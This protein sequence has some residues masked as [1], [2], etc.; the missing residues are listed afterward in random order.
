MIELRTIWLGDDDPVSGSINDLL[1]GLINFHEQYDLRLFIEDFQN[2]TEE[3]KKNEEKRK[4][5][6]N[7]GV[8]IWSL[9]EEERELVKP[10]AEH[11]QEIRE[12][13]QCTEQ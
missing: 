13:Y 4:R 1:E 6:Q 2:K 9:K 8:F 10:I 7:G 5:V 12:K 3:I 11:M